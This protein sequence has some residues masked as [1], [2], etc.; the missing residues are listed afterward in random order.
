MTAFARGDR[1]VVTEFV[2]RG[3][4]ADISDIDGW[5]VQI[6]DRTVTIASTPDWEDLEFEK[7]YFTATY[8]LSDVIVSPFGRAVATEAGGVTVALIMFVLFAIGLACVLY[9]ALGRSAPLLAGG[10]I[11]ALTCWWLGALASEGTD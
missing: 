5:L 4:D 2:R 7:D 11:L 9:G 10:I 8:L 1:V 3:G 6:T